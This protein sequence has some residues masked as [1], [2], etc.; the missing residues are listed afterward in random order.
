MTAT[1]T[2][3]VL[4]DDNA[5]ESF[6]KMLIGNADTQQGEE[7]G[8][9]IDPEEEAEDAPAENPEEEQ[10]PDENPEEKD[11]VAEFTV[12]IDGKEQKVTADE[13]IKGYQ[14]TADYTRKTQEAAEL[15]KTANA[16]LEAAKSERAHYQQNLERLQHMI[17]QSAP[18][19]PDWV[20]LATEN[21]AEYVR[22][23]A[24]FAQYRA[25]QQALESER[26]QLTER[27]QAEQERVA[28]QA[29]SEEKVKLL[30]AIPE[31][32]DAKRLK[33]DKA[34]LQDFASSVGFTPEDIDTVDDHRVLVILRKAM[35]Y[36]KAVAARS[37]RPVQPIGPKSATPGAPATRSTVGNL[38]RAQQ[39]FAKDRSDEAA[40][41][42]FLHMMKPA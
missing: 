15:R 18:Q 6:E 16:E 32:K 4:T 9:E 36:D 10:D 23:Q 22:Q 38:A 17:Q 35:L 42:V 34:A 39:R 14:R 8:A 28:Q 11:P 3:S 40:A 7:E 19:E 13:L 2:T 31:W 5:A 20:Q 21:P 33:A 25:R 41:D 37:L 27:E 1:E 12:K 29:R 30:D 24:L 26:Q